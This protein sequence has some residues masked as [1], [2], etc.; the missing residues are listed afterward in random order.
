MSSSPFARSSLPPGMNVGSAAGNTGGPG[1]SA[2]G[3]G[4]IGSG[5]GSGSAFGGGGGLG[6][7]AHRAAAAA[8]TA[9]QQVGSGS[10]NN[11]DFPALNAP[12]QPPMF[13]A[14]G[15]PGPGSAAVAAAVAAA[16]AEQASAVAAL[17][18]QASQREA[19]RLGILNGSPQASNRVLSAARGG[20]GDLERN[21]ATKLGSSQISGLP[22]LSPN[23][24]SGAQSWSRV[25]GGGPDGRSGGNVN[26]VG[27]SSGSVTSV[28]TPASQILFSAADRFGLAG[29]LRIIK[30]Q[31]SGLGAGGANGANPE[32]VGL[33]SLGND[34]QSLGLDVSAENPLHSDFHTPW[35]SDLHPMQRNQRAMVEPEFHLPSCYNVQPPP[36]AQNKVA[37]FSDE[38]LFFI[39]YSTPRDLL[40]EVAA[41]ELHHR[42]WRYHKEL[43]LWLTKEHDMEPIQKTAMYEKGHYVFWDVDSWKRVTRKFMLLYELLEDRP[44]LG[45]PQPQQQQQQQ[46]LLQHQQQQHSNSSSNPQQ[47]QQSTLSSVAPTTPGAPSHSNAT[48]A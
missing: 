9:A 14:N 30:L 17:Q 25:G 4:S 15:A 21:Y 44:P 19:H 35:S 46:Q 36:P 26:G 12:T 5:S 13:A 1:A 43:Q 16:A 37:N 10:F 28:T 2:P 24:G 23:T 34:L 45:G 41:M 18:H 29:L 27:P 20:F 6:G 31:A 3:Q 33:L 32:D 47:Q 22:A 11:D 8:V 48:P 38:T 7:A 39:F 42:N 40:Q